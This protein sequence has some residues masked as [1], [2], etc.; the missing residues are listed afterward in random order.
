MAL[1]VRG[2]FATPAAARDP[3]IAL[4]FTRAAWRN[5]PHAKQLD[6]DVATGLRPEGM[7]MIVLDT[8]HGMQAVLDAPLNQR[9]DALR[10]MLSPAAGMFRYVPGDVDL[11]A[12]HAM[13][14][15]FP[16]DR[17][18]AEV[19][20]A[21]ERLRDADAWHRIER[22]LRE[23]IAL[24]T[25]A[26]PGITVPDVTFVLVVGDPDDA[27]FM[28]PSRGLSGNGSVPGFILLTLWPTDE[29]LAR[30]EAS[31]VHELGHNIRFAP[32][33]AR[34]DPAR[35][36]V[37]DHVVAEG[38]ADAFAR[39]IYG[40]AGFTPFGVPHLDDDEV[41]AKVVSG[42]QVHGMQH[43]AA[44]VLGD[45]AAI[46]F[47]SQPVGLPMAA[48]YAAGNRLLDAYLA[49]TGKT[50]AEAVHD[51]S[52]E[53]VAVALDAGGI[54]ANAGSMVRSDGPRHD[55]KEGA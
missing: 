31:A 38:L 3:A 10:A 15:G 44:W 7:T 40:D 49:A 13:S 37:G 43:F 48:G 24:Q 26:T 46:R 55:G 42:L 50:A 35:V 23:A 28:G 33:D 12:M 51:A 25:A 14:L 30:L 21:L 27:Y 18:N 53:I 1:D 11:A 45:P 36:V 16:V 17:R 47:G 6:I 54:E 5:R 39:Q 41:F 34:W 19:R 52:D 4:L 2:L 20:H 29:N 8:D 22:A 32:G 9:A